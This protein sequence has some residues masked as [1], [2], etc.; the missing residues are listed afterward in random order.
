[1]MRQLIIHEPEDPMGFLIDKLKNPDGKK[2]F[3]VGPPGSNVRELTLQLS[4][5]F[6]TVV[7]S[8]GD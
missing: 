4:D 3:V 5:H 6:E 1:M 7:V 2:L 8:V